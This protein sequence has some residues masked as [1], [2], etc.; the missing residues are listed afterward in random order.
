MCVVWE[1]TDKNSS[2]YQ[3]WELWPEVWSKMGKAAQKK[4]KREW[5][6]E[7]P[8]LDNV[9]KLRGIYFIDR[10]D[11]EYKETFKKNQEE[12]WVKDVSGSYA[13]FTEQGSYQHHKSQQQKSWISYPDCQVAQD[14]QRTQHLF[15]PRS[16]WKM[17]QNYWK[18]QSQNVQTFGFVF[19]DT[20][21]QN[22]GQTLKIR[23]F[24]LNEN[25][26]DI[27]L[28]VS[29]V[30][31]S[32]EDILMEL[33][34]EKSAELGMPV[35]SSKTRIILVGTRGWHQN[36]WKEAEY[37][38]HV[39][40]KLMKTVEYGRT[41][42]I[43]RPCVL[44]M[45]SAWLQIDE[46]IMEQFQK[47][48]ESRISAGAAD[49]LPGWEKS[50]TKTVAWS[51]RH[52]R[53]CSEM[54]WTKTWTGKQESGATL[55]S[56]KPLFGWSSIQAGRTWISRTI[57]ISLLPNGSEMLVLGTKWTTWHSVVS[58]QICSISHQMDNSLWPTFSSFDF[59][60]S[61]HMWL[62]TILSCGKH[63]SAL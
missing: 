13:V 60:Y 54:C 39:E 32:S 37:G 61:P 19:H 56:V 49:K 16:T 48:L 2:N 34:W 21:D 28:L 25:F 55:Q 44:G 31:D 27:H 63:G 22:H 10:E 24:L 30:K 52:G 38:S 53:T 35:R 5:A 11:G 46:T 50:Q 29:C 6:N 45:Y 42:I 9:Q 62:Q 8:E 14:K 51:L 58:E 20:N 36:G 18:F 7:K 1:D 17:L 12:S 15:V 33:R 57:V 40:K 23:W 26:S 43:S 4:E 3:T 41:H 59:T 47:M